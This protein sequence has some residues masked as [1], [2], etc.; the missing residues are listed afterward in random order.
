MVNTLKV[1]CLSSQKQNKLPTVHY[2]V[3]TW[4]YNSNLTIIYFFTLHKFITN[5]ANCMV[6]GGLDWW[7]QE[8]GHRKWK[9]QFISSLK[10]FI[11]WF[12]RYAFSFHLVD[13]AIDSGGC[14]SYWFTTYLW[15]WMTK[16]INEMISVQELFL[17]WLKCDTHCSNMH[18][19]S[20]TH[21]SAFL[22]NTVIQM[23][24][25]HDQSTHHSTHHT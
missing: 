21:C 24:T 17:M 10:L 22:G 19:S 15:Q 11:K 6:V 8:H 14:S 5:N 18:T 9:E 2:N 7:H 13:S 4:L 20:V 23:H 25:V 1:I 12:H 16:L 3:H